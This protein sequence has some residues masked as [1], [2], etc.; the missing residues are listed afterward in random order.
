MR[1]LGKSLRSR[2]GQLRADICRGLFSNCSNSAT[3]PAARVHNRES[4]TRAGRG[5]E[6]IRLDGLAE[7]VQEVL[8]LA[9]LLPDGVERAWVVGHVLARRAEAVLI[10]EVV[11]GGPSDLGHCDSMLRCSMPSRLDGSELEG[12]G[13]ESDG[14]RQRRAR[15]RETYS[16]C[17]FLLGFDCFLDREVERQ[18]TVRCFVGVARGVYFKCRS[19]MAGSQTRQQVS[20][21]R[22]RVGGAQARG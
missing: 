20:F 9:G 15:R 12:R 2:N 6:N 13:G 3:C 1:P 8:D 5:L 7:R 21:R 11:A 18:K 22:L 17:L 14:R 16:F 4:N 10:R 19:P